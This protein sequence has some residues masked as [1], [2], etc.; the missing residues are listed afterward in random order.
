MQASI[1][2]LY[3][4]YLYNTHRILQYT[5]ILDPNLTDV[6]ERLSNTSRRR[7]P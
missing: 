7:L 1:S 3:S 4:L 2:L 6:Q 5:S